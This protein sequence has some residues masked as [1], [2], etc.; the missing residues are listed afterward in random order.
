MMDNKQHGCSVPEFLPALM[1]H[2]ELKHKNVV[3]KLE[4]YI[5]VRKAIGMIDLVGNACICA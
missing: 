5:S 4:A 2:T 3:D 1:K